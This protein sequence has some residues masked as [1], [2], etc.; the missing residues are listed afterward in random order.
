MRETYKAVFLGN[1]NV[2]KT[3]LMS[4]YLYKKVEK[5]Y[6]PTIGLDFVNI[7]ITVSG[8]KLRLQLWDTA[9]QERFDSLIPNY[10]RKSFMTIV[11][12]DLSDDASFKRTNHWIN[13]LVRVHDPNRLIKIIL[14]GN[15]SDLVDEKTRAKY[16]EEGNRRAKEHG[17]QYVE[18]CAMKHDGIQEL[19]K[20]VL[21]LIEED[22]AKNPDTET[23][24]KEVIN[25]DNSSKTGCCG[26]F[27]R[28]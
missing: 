7:S 20:A 14:V 24:K 10:T 11:V 2:G 15:K 8:Q 27:R 6:G 19:V 18:T 23:D 12:F 26:G 5:S 28:N 4:Q 16:R 3:T 25:L 13:D 9:G 17:G 21:E 22:I 1:S